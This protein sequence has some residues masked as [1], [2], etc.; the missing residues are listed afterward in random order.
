MDKI[1]WVRAI[2]NGLLVVFLFI[3]MATLIGT[4]VGAA[5]GFAM[6]GEGRA[7]DIAS[8]VPRQMAEMFATWWVALILAALGA[9][10]VYWRARAVAK[11][12]P[13]KAMPNALIVGAVPALL[14]L[15]NG[16]NGSILLTLI[17]VAAN[18]G[19]AAYA[20]YVV[21]NQADARALSADPA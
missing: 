14:N 8:V 18:L 15:L 10:L 2:L 5:T 4:I 16:L 9:L 17:Y 7:N 21:G 20:G 3:V 12:G 19:A 11:R 1:H 6:V 13:M